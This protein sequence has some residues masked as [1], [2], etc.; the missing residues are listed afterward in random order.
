MKRS[1]QRVVATSAGLLFVGVF[2]VALFQNCSKFEAGGPAVTAVESSA[3]SMIEE[4]SGVKLLSATAEDAMTCTVSYDVTELDVTGLPITKTYNFT[5]KPTPA[6]AGSTKRVDM[7]VPAVNSASR[8]I[9]LVTNMTC[10]ATV[11]AV[12]MSYKVPYSVVCALKAKP[13][14][15]LFALKTFEYQQ[16]A[17]DENGKVM[18]Q[19]YFFTRADEA[20]YQSLG[21]RLLTPDRPPVVTPPTGA[22]TWYEQVVAYGVEYQFKD[23]HCMPSGRNEGWACRYQGY[24][25]DASMGGASFTGNFTNQSYCRCMEAVPSTYNANGNCQ[26]PTF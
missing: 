17:L 23:A 20:R 11:T 1:K 9:G 10:P 13:D 12:K 26:Q 24:P 21:C 22:C 5:I 18:S 25:Y 16:N 15:S 2:G 3:N 14:G 6:I 4:T 7:P 8:A 19:Q